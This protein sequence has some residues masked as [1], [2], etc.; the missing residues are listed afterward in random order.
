MISGI[1]PPRI[2]WL[3]NPCHL[4]SYWLDTRS[5]GIGIDPTNDDR[6]TSPSQRNLT[7]PLLTIDST[8]VDRLC[9][10]G[11]DPTPYN[12]MVVHVSLF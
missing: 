3:R 8:R 6:H 9:W 11:E 7:I 4:F 10:Q 1:S 12:R 5:T 2:A